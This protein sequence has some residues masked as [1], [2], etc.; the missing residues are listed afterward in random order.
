MDFAYDPRT[1]EMRARVQSFMDAHIIPRI[2]QYHEETHAG[3]Y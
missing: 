1:E 2:R 3:N